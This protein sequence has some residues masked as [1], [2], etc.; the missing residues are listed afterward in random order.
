MCVFVL[1]ARAAMVIL[2]IICQFIA[3][4]WYGLTYIPGA[5]TAVSACFR[6]FFA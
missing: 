3:L 6:G 1:F 4:T 5:Q 2:C